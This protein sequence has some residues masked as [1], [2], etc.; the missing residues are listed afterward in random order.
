MNKKTLSRPGLTGFEMGLCHFTI[1]STVP[2]VIREK[3]MVVMCGVEI[4]CGANVMLN[5][6]INQ[7]RECRFGSVLMSG[8]RRC[9]GEI[10]QKSGQ[11]RLPNQAVTA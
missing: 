3:M 2:G 5:N 6:S 4:H 8:C 10:Q 9:Y 1:P 11:K 7:T